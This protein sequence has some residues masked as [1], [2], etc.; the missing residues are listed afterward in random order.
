MSRRL[1]RH[2]GRLPGMVGGDGASATAVAMMELGHDQAAVK[3]HL[4]V[5]ADRWRFVGGVA[6]MV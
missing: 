2:Q 3:N 4:P 5:V 6:T 1:A